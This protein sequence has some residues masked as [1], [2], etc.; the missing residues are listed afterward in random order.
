[1]LGDLWRESGRR[2]DELKSNGEDS[3]RTIRWRVPHS[4]S[5]RKPHAT[6]RTKQT[7]M[8]INSSTRKSE[9]RSFND[10][11]TGGICNRE[12]SSLLLE[13]SVVVWWATDLISSLNLVD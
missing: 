1:M 13:M 8:L 2:H 4:I 6:I 12:A 9:N 11:I 3:D 10:K 5:K 7:A